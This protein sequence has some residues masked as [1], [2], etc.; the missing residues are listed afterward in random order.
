MTKPPL[1]PTEVQTIRPMSTKKVIQQS[2]VH[3][4]YNDAGEVH[5]YD[6]QGK[7][8]EGWPEGWPDKIADVKTFMR[9]R[10]INLIK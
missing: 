2:E 10:G 8:L 7:E 4:A 9:E 3:Y 5:L 6:R 1:T